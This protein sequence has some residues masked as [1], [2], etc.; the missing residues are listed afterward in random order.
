MENFEQKLKRLEE[1]SQVIKQSDVSLEDALKAFE[2]GI[3]L[4]KG[5][6]KT[7]DEMEGKIQ[8]LMN[9]PAPEEAPAKKE[10]SQKKET[11]SEKDGPV[12]DFF[13]EMTQING[14][15]S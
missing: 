10:K 8:I 6:E 7:L 3:K 12:L 2:E 1:L 15:R 13:N 9:S 4:S 5:M 14:T 11:A